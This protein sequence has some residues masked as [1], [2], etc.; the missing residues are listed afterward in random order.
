M[1]NSSEIVF[2]SR[3]DSDGGRWFKRTRVRAHGG[4]GKYYES[5]GYHGAFR[6]E[7]I[8]HGCNVPPIGASGDMASLT[9]LHTA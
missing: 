1:K 3:S 9:S 4:A 7:Q 5:P 2:N 8:V 6:N